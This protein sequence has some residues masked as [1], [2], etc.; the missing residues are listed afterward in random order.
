MRTVLLVTFALLP[1]GE[2][3]GGLVVAALAD[4]GISS[5]WV[6]W[7]DPTVDWA[8]ADL[9]AV[10]SAWDYH[11]RAAEFL[12]WAR[13]VEQETRLL[14][15]A[16]L[17]DWNR[18]KAYLTDLGDLPVVP[19]ALLD[20]AN[21]VAGLQAA[22]DRFGT[23]VIKPRTGAGGVGVVVAQ[24]TSDHRLEGLTTAP[25]IVQPLVES[26]RTEGES[27]VYAFDGRAVCQVDKLPVGD[28][29]RVHE[30]Y[31]GGSRPGV[32]GDESAA[33]AER[34]VEAVADRF[35]SV[36][37]YARVDM[38]RYDGRLAVS[39]LEL[40]EPGLY[41]DVIPENAG[42]FAELVAGYV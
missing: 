14:N 9:V 33:L 26:V 40:I 19:T 34:A 3:G 28:E 22:V 12:A 38:M 23:V 37:A 36:P 16:D 20:D 2:P 18:D 35:G 10:R 42:R 32:L 31:G 41:L 13:A 24:S 39:E 11:R 6:S 27:S 7:D 21:L 29:I 30:Q 8:A 25:W 4:K 17:F 1:R 15:G 5:R